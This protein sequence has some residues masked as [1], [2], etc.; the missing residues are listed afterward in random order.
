MMMTLNLLCFGSV[1][2]SVECL[3]TFGRGDHPNTHTW[4]TPTQFRTCCVS[5]WW[6]TLTRKPLLVNAQPYTLNTEL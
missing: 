3:G 4:C 6:L 2:H 1:V 5:G